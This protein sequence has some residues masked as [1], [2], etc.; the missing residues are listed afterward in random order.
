MNAL[1]GGGGRGVWET[2][3]FD[4]GRASG[5]FGEDRVILHLLTTSGYDPL[6]FVHDHSPLPMRP[7]NR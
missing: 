7:C 2:A 3:D 5:V 1:N 4:R 6:V